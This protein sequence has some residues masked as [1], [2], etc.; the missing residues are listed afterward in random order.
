MQ[1]TKSMKLA[2]AGSASALAVAI[3]AGA[4]ALAQIDEITVR[5]TK[6]E[7]NLQTTPV[8]VTALQAEA[9]DSIVAR[10]IGDVAVLVPNFSAAKVTGFNA[11]SFAMRGAGQTDIIVYSEPSVGVVID[12]F[13]VPHVQTQLL[14]IFD[15][16]Q[17]EVLRGPQG[18]LFGKNTTAGVVSLRTKR[19]DLE[20]A[21]VK[22]SARVA[23]YGRREGRFAVNAPIVTDTLALRFSGLYV[24][25]DGYYRNG[26]EFGPLTPFVPIPGVTGAT[27]QGDG[28]RLGGEDVFS[29]RA[30]LLWQP[31]DNFNALFQYE[32]IRDNS[33][34]VPS[35]NETPVGDPRFVFNNLGFTQDVGGDPLDN[36]A[37]TG[38]ND[39]LLNMGDGHQ[40][41]VD[42][43]YLNMEWDTGPVQITSVTG[44]REQQS[45]LPSTY[46]GEVGPVSLFDANRADDRETFQQEIRFAGQLTDRFDI[47]AGGFYQDNDVVFCVTQVLGFLDLFG[48]GLPFGTFNNGGQALCNAQDARAAAGFVDGVY[49]VTDRLSVGGGFRFTWEEKEWIGRNQ[50]VYEAIL[51]VNANELTDPLAASDFSLAADSVLSD[52]EEWSEPSW[53]ATA[54][55]QFT[56]DV[57]GYFTASR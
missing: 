55:Y 10:D 6:R 9:V 27:G 35:I 16:E 14:D 46:T 13:V 17:V 53:R 7:T 30:K 25:S 1:L 45:R 54:S 18:T 40:V 31:S 47:V 19:P 44:Y 56:D 33:D 4:P 8:S 51:G 28:S 49:Q 12:D 5:A 21:G 34:D 15:I 48:L 2:L 50:Q 23:S 29:G 41:D 22:A 24:K 26:A 38:R 42:G 37:S 43:F 3:G 32:I 20:K 11:A 36:A 39:Q 57:Y 52:S